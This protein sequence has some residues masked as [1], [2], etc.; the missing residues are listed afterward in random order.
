MKNIPN[1]MMVHTYFTPTRPVLVKG[2]T[3]KCSI[4]FSSNVGVRTEHG[5]PK[6]CT[7]GITDP[8]SLIRLSTDVNVREFSSRQPEKRSS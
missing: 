6:S 3:S 8:V 4:T 7:C 1:E 5:L 2:F